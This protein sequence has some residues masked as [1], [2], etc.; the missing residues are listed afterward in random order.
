MPFFCPL[1]K[2]LSIEVRLASGLWTNVPG[3]SKQ[4]LHGSRPR[5]SSWIRG[6]NAHG[7][8]RAG[9][10]GGK[11]LSRFHRLPPPPH[12]IWERGGHPGGIS[13]TTPATK[14]F[15]LHRWQDC[16]PSCAARGRPVGSAARDVRRPAAPGPEAFAA[17]PCVLGEPTDE[18]PGTC[19]VRHPQAGV[20]G[21]WL[22]ARLGNAEEFVDLR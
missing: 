13:W 21:L 19:S 18:L 4:R 9:G 11:R 8:T 3:L 2:Q 5:F 22:R 17:A 15:P 16:W 12:G 20:P 7:N 10:S 14:G 6:A 1:V